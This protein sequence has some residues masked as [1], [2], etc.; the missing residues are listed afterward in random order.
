LE[1]L[2][3]RRH[4]D[5]PPVAVEAFRHEPAG[6]YYL[7]V[8]ELVPYKRI[9]LAVRTFFEKRPQA[10]DRG[11]R[12]GIFALRR[13]AAPNIEFCGRVG[14]DGLRS[15]YARCRAFLMPGEEDFGITTV[16]ALASGKAIIALGRGGVLEIVPRRARFFPIASGRLFGSGYPGFESSEE[17]SIG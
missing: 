13:M 11:R 4:G 10:A 8:S 5:P 12:A 6:D 7:I 14:D 9:D 15:L 17:L 3:A 1:N 16:E 2:P